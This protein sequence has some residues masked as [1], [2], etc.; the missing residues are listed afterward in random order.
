MLNDS[1]TTRTI[2]GLFTYDSTYV[3]GLTAEQYGK[4]IHVI[5]MIANASSNIIITIDSSIKPRISF[6]TKAL[7]YTS[8]NYTNQLQVNVVVSANGYISC[9]CDGTYKYTA[10]DVWY[11]TN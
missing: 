7:N 2:N 9:D 11:L 6:S 4:L 10:F 8:W 1:L 5:G 3:S